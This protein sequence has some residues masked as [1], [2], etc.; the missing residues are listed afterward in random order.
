M[1][2]NNQIS[3]NL[4]VLESRTEQIE[5]RMEEVRVR[6]EESIKQREQLLR[7]LE[8]ASQLTRRDQEKIEAEKEQLKLDLKQQVS[9]SYVV[10]HVDAGRL[11]GH[12]WKES[13]VIIN[14]V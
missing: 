13:N 5:E 1:Q 10:S 11:N 8:I 7:E 9:C 3:K 12:F 14:S 4:Q 2:F 6:H